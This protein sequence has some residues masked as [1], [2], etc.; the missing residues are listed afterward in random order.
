M[1]D[2][3]AFAPAQFDVV[4]QPVSSSYLPD[5]RQL[6]AAVARVSKRGGLYVSQHKQPA[7]LQAGVVAPWTLAIP[8]SESLSLPSVSDQ[9]HREVG[10]QE[11][12]HTHEALLGALC[13]AGFIIE[14]I[15][16]PLLADCFAPDNS[17]E[18]RAF[19]LPPY[20]KIKARRTS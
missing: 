19:Y 17:A 10:T 16:E 2:L 7:S 14:D 18:Q 9:R 8:Y 6:Y 11:Y 13:R 1:D 12:L 4:V 15:N 3:Q 20:I 5:L